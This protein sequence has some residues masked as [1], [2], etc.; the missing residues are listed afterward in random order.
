M[1][2]GKPTA[3]DLELEFEGSRA[4]VIWDS[5]SLGSFRVKARVEINPTLL[6]KDGGTSGS[7]FL[8][9]GELV[10]PRPENN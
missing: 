1:D 8:Y 9:R 3:V 6:Q 7:S 10:L 2:K 5:I 4:F